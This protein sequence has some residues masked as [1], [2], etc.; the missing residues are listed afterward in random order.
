VEGV[1]RDAHFRHG[2]YRDSIIMGLLEGE[3]KL[4]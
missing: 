4:D 3:L 2:A 1:R